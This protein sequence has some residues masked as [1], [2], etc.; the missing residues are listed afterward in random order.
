M[1]IVYFF[2]LRFFTFVKT[3]TPLVDT[4]KMILSDS[5]RVFRVTSKFAL[6]VDE[7]TQK[8]NTKDWQVGKTTNIL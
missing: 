2:L 8:M 6:P 4:S 7:Q 1:A 3:Y 5:Q